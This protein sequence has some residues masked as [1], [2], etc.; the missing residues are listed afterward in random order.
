MEKDILSMPNFSE[1]ITGTPLPQRQNTPE[2][3]TFISTV[4]Q[5]TYNVLQQYC[6]KYFIDFDELSPD[7]ITIVFNNFY[8][9][10]ALTMFVKK[11]FHYSKLWCTCYFTMDKS[12]KKMVYKIKENF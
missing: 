3:D 9:D 12:Q 10:P 5:K 8:I 6:D 2:D 1:F 4:H 7:D 11:Y